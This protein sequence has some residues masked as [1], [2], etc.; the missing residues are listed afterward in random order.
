MQEN[1]ELLVLNGYLAVIIDERKYLVDTGM[2][3]S[4]CYSYTNTLKLNNL[5]FKIRNFGNVKKCVFDELTGASIDGLIGMDIISKTGLVIDFKNKLIEFGDDCSKSDFIINFD[6]FNEQKLINVDGFVIN[7]NEVKNVLFD[8]CAPNPYVMN[9]YLSV[10]TNEL[11]YEYSPYY[12][13]ATG[14]LFE[15]YYDVCNHT[16]FKKAIPSGDNLNMNQTF[17]A[18]YVDALLGW[19][20]FND[21][22]KLVINVDEMKIYIL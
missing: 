6:Y 10:K 9:K 21:I 20:I 16:Y 12:G 14:Y 2:E 19:S 3:Y 4:F 22:T 15:A 5:Y 11:Y 17:L 13:E 18:H 7:E 1:H 8:T